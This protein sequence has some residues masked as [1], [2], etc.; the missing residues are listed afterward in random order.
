MDAFY[1]GIV[2]PGPAEDFSRPA[3]AA[4]S[5]GRMRRFAPEV[6]ADRRSG[7]SLA[8]NTDRLDA[9]QCGETAARA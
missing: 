5:G 2:S 9:T 7:A 4:F 8:G 3:Q 6:A 1:G